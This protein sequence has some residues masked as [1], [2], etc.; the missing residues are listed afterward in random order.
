[1]A[2]SRSEGQPA[3]WGAPITSCGRSASKFIGPHA[4]L[5]LQPS[6]VPQHCLPNTP[7]GAAMLAPFSSKTLVDDQQT[8][9]DTV[10]MDRFD[11]INGAC[12]ETNRTDENEMILA[13]VLMNE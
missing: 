3:T 12:P 6:G 4:R 11:I 9:D 7:N 8:S 10:V 2:S 1:M 5:K 13:F